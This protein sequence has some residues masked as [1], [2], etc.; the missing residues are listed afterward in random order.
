VNRL[1]ALILNTVLPGAGVALR[2]PGLW[3]AVPLAVG[4]GGVS[5]LVVA[6]VAPGTHAAVMTGWAGLL[7]YLAA[8]LVA[9]IAWMLLEQP[10]S[11]DLA[12]IQPLFREV[13]AAYLG[14]RLP[15]AEQAARRLARLAAGE[16]GAWRLL[17]MVLRA[18]GRTAAA[19]RL[20]R[21]AARL[22]LVRR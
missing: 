2:H 11:R 5:L 10:S 6:L 1:T 9:G 8:V 19:E 20:D 7:A 18:E 13:A 17:A 14:G 15:Q 12:A 22:D 21:R 16:P 3:A 4:V